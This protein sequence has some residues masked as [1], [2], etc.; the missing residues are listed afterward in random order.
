M[1]KK[2]Q[3]P[4]RQSATKG[5]LISEAQARPSAVWRRLVQ[6]ATGPRVDPGLLF[7][8]LR[9]VDQVVLGGLAVGLTKVQFDCMLAR[10]SPVAELALECGAQI[11][12]GGS[13]RA[14]CFVRQDFGNI[15]LFLN[16]IQW[17][18]GEVLQAEA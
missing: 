6:C 11:V 14:Q 2:N 10:E 4:D 9:H 3:G 17:Q 1:C 5:R 16:L 8:Q 12:L 13:H 18:L 7:L 15:L